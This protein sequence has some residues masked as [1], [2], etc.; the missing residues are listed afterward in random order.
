MSSMTHRLLLYRMT[1][2]IT[3]T[4]LLTSPRQLATIGGCVD[5]WRLQESSRWEIMKGMRCEGEGGRKEQEER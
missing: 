1:A 4:Q 2:R 3:S 5:N